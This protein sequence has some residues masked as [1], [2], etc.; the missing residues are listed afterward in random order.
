MLWGPPLKGSCCEQVERFEGEV[1]TFKKL[2]GKY[3][4]DVR[5]PEDDTGGETEE[6]TDH[7][8][9]E[10]NDSR[11]SMRQPSAAD[12]GGNTEVSI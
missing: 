6:D 3:G 9:E 8:T 7:E 4:N 5:N 1:V 11:P 10:G 12:H 2:W